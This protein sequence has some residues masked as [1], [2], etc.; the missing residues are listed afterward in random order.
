MQW[1]TYPLFGN[2]SARQTLGYLEPTL[3]KMCQT[4]AIGGGSINVR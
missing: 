1:N 4:E 3:Y 2:N